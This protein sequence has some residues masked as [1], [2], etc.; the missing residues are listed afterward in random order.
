MSA[1]LCWSCRE[2]RAD[3]CARRFIGWPDAAISTCPGGCYEPGADAA[4]RDYEENGDLRRSRHEGMPS[5]G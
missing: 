5:G 2:Y 3:G 4:E 1:L